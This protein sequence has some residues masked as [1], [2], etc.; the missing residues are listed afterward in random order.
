MPSFLVFDCLVSNGQNVMHLNFRDRLKAAEG[1]ILNNHTV[2]RLYMEQD[3]EIQKTLPPAAQRPP[4]AMLYMKDVFEVWQVPN[5]FDL[6]HPNKGLLMHENDGLIFTVDACPYYP[7][8]CPEIIKWKPA[9]LNSIDFELKRLGEFADAAIWGLYVQDG[10]GP[11][12]VK[13]WAFHVFDRRHGA[14]GATGTVSEAELLKLGQRQDSGGRRR[15]V[16]VECGYD[17]AAEPPRV[18]ILLRKLV[19]EWKRRG[20]DLLDGS[21]P[22]ADLLKGLPPDRGL[23]SLTSGDI[24]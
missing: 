17:A 1:Y 12:A 3:N 23:N 19:D 15:R 22:I 6:I 13:L 20:Q 2:Y 7:G 10:R 16:I 24:S 8:T 18:L 21:T 4:C 14:Q 11:D 9:H 5:L